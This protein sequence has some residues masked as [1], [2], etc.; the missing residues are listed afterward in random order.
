MLKSAGHNYEVDY[1]DEIV[2][3]YEKTR[4][5]SDVE[6]SRI[7]KWSD[8]SYIQLMQ[9][10]KQRKTLQDACDVKDVVKNSIILILNLFDDKCQIETETPLEELS[11]EE[12]K[13][14]RKAMLEALE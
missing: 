13:K 9:D 12:K 5:A 1:Y 7:E 3:F 2:Q 8:F 10:I 6:K 4:R 14:V 11:E